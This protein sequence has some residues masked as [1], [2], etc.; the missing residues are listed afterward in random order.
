MTSAAPIT[1]CRSCGSKSLDAVLDL[2]S[3]P[4]ANEL[5]ED[6]TQ[7]QIEYPLAVVLCRACTLVQNSHR[8]PGEILFGQSYPY[9]SS[10]STA[11]LDHARQN[12][13]EL[14]EA[15]ELGS[16]SLVIE[17]ASNDGYLLKNFV[18]RGIPVLGIDPAEGPAAMARE[19]GIA[20][21]VEYF[22]VEVAQR[23]RDE[24]LRADVILGNNVMAHVDDI[25]DLVAGVALLLRD[26]GVAV[27]EA[28]YLVDLV[29]RCAFD[30]I[31]H[32]HNC[33]FSLT[34]LQHLFTRHGLQLLDLRRL[35]VHGGSL[36]IYAGSSGEPSPAVKECLAQEEAL[37]LAELG[38][39]ESFGERVD[40]ILGSLRTML[41]ELRAEGKQVAAY[42]AAAKGA[43]ITSVAG[44]DESDIS[45]VVDR[46]P[47]K[48]GRYMPGSQIAIV[49]PAR[50]ESEPPDYLLL[51][52]W[53]LAQEIRSQLTGFHG[54]YIVPIP[55]PRVL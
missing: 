13:L 50:L 22:G 34:A 4:L 8:V 33:Y 55:E 17:V 16:D 25:N 19:S 28:P 5:R 31:Y 15:R 11:Y 26:D 27:F 1:I 52:A 20:T 9:F 21:R 42:G 18:E 35:D 2:G 37:G 23:I 49:S 53:N 40:G 39:Y 51:F 47:H 45:Y 7:K 48:Q 12:A 44:L 30:T 29:Q 54:R 46:N 3:T 41:A 38:Y 43:V 6:P 24:G 14:I 32:E 10:V 36:R